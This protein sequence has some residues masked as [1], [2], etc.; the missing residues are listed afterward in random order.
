M[1]GWK[2]NGECR[3]RGEK[4][5]C[6]CRGTEHDGIHLWSECRRKRH[7]G[8]EAGFRCASDMRVREREKGR[9]EKIM[10]LIPVWFHFVSFICYPE[11]LRE[12]WLVSIAWAKKYRDLCWMKHLFF[13]FPLLL[14]S[15]CL[16]KKV[17]VSY[18]GGEP[19]KPHLIFEWKL[20]CTYF[21]PHTSGNR[22]VMCSRPKLTVCLHVCIS[23]PQTH[24]VWVCTP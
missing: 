19:F 18:S 4:K 10:Q 6:T 23:E 1:R 17:R 9:R 24:G 11:C 8:K 22:C 7:W 15:F 12:A 21:C 5:A 3:G 14:S 2:E 13:S 20:V 16:H